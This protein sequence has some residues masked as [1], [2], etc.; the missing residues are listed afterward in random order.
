MLVLPIHLPLEHWPIQF[1]SHLLCL[2]VEIAHALH[3]A[4]LSPGSWAYCIAPDMV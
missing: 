1:V 3:V 4:I 2:G